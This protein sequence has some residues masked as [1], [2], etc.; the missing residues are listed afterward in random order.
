MTDVSTSP[1]SGYGVRRT[2]SPQRVRDGLA[3][4]ELVRLA[5]A[6]PWI[7]FGTMLLLS[8]LTTTWFGF[9]TPT[10]RAGATLLVE[11]EAPAGGVLG[12]LASLTAQPIA[13]GEMELLRS[14]TVAEATVAA[15]PDGDLADWP[16]RHLGLATLVEDRALRPLTLKIAAMRDASPPAA[17]IRAAFD[18]DAPHDEVWLR[19]EG[20]DV[21]VK[22]AGWLA[23]WG[24][25]ELG[26]WPIAGNGATEIPELGLRLW[27]EGW[28][29]G[30]SFRVHR[31]D[32]ETA[33][34]RLRKATRVAEAERNTGIVR[35]TVDD[36][37]PGRAAATVNAL[38][39][40][41]LAAS[42]AR[43]KR[44]ASQTL[45]FLE[46]QLATQL[47]AL[48]SAEN[49]L[50]D[51]RE[52]SPDLVNVPETTRVWI[53]SATALAVEG[54]RLELAERA[55]TEAR[56][57]YG[58]GALTALGRLDE[59]T[60]FDPVFTA[61][62][63]AHERLRERRTGLAAIVTASHPDLIELEAALTASAA[64]LGEVLVEKQRALDARVTE[65]ESQRAELE[66]NLAGLPATERAVA[67]PLRR[68]ET[69]RN[70]YAF[71]STSQQEAQLTFAS[72]IA[73]A[74]LI[75]PAVRPTERHAPRL[76]G[77]G[78]LSL[79]LGLAL[80]LAF[81][82]I[83]DVRLGPV[84]DAAQFEEATG[85]AVL[86]SIPDFR[87]G[88]ARVRGAGA[89]FLALRDAPEH[90]AAEAYRGLRAT[91]RRLPNGA[92][93]VHV[94]ATSAAPGEGKS[95]TNIDLALAFAAAGRRVL[96]VDADLRKPSVHRYLG[97]ERGP[98]LAE[99]LAGDI[100]WRSAVRTSE[101]GLSVL[102]AGRASG[103]RGDL[104]GS[105]RMTTLVDEFAAD[106]DI[107]VYDLPPA[108]AVADA[109]DFA[110]RLDAMLLVYRVGGLPR[111]ALVE[112][113]RRLEHVDAPLVG[114]VLNA[115]R[116]SRGTMKRYGYGYYG[117]DEA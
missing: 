77:I 49:E 67:D 116:P 108:L 6:R 64:E 36:S 91:L 111:T 83:V 16:E 2:P 82:R 10:Y 87:V 14:R 112:A 12:Q 9:K 19:F 60:L 69:H 80:G 15:P 72:T 88:A 8:A 94:A 70:V 13:A 43:G 37:D 57:G 30:R 28:P 63:A 1:L 24:G 11:S 4:S 107:V 115:V 74:D 71:L 3:W 50:V 47:K 79:F 96:L 76:F 113:K 65:I 81:A 18:E 103:P 21:R 58:A 104:F 40:N 93:S 34:K 68:Y 52:A 48:E 99:A 101:Q 109:A 56:E 38:C 110:H 100:D 86:A 39:A 45:E 102:T 32:T 106:M 105:E 20:G 61:R 97:L 55:L 51:L 62:V 66:A 41:Y 78:A 117:D 46:A 5:G 85:L 29:T 54:T 98:G 17:S 75:D 90:A 7:V 33:V 89:E 84:E 73:S 59:P 114:G 31:V 44:R 23:E 53:E 92:S 35:V 22:S 42:L 27:V 26:R 95:T 25:E